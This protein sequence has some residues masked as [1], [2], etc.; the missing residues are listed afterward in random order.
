MDWRLRKEFNKLAYINRK[1]IYIRN[2]S[3]TKEE[4]HRVKLIKQLSSNKELEIEA[5][6]TKILNEE[7]KK[8]IND[9][10]KY[11]KDK[12]S[13]CK[14]QRMRRKNQFILITNIVTSLS[15]SLF[16]V[17]NINFTI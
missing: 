4:I 10:T 13:T 11:Y 16:L 1:S 17:T 12:T 14:L 5:Y 8:I 6:K 2:C 7:D 3:K 9:S 15:P